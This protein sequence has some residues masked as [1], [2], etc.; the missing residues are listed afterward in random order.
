MYK[1]LVVDEEDELFDDF[2]DY[3]EISPLKSDFE[4]H[5]QYPLAHGKRI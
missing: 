4:I 1:L 5:T 2:L 3:W